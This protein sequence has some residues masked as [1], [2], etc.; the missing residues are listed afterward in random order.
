MQSSQFSVFEWLVLVQHELLLFAAIFFLVGAFDELVVDLVWL[1]L[2]LT[3]R[4]R[5]RTVPDDLANAATLEGQAAVSIP[6]WGEAAVVGTTVRYLLSVWRQESLRL[7]V[8]LLY[9]SP[10]PRD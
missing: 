9:T 5:D 8:C 10:S 4:A 1:W 3:G 6:A 7:Y 2:R